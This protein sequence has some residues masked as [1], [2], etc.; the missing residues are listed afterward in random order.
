MKKR[1]KFYSPLINFPDRQQRIFRNV[2][3]IRL[4][5]KVHEVLEGYKTYADLPGEVEWCLLHPKDIDRQ[6]K[7]NALY[8]TIG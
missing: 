8:E 2:K 7:Q 4:R 6:E 1:I 5:N 3:T